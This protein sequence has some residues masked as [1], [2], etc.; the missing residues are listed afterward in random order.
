V[1][2]DA[3]I[4]TAY[5]SRLADYTTEAEIRASHILFR[6]EGQDEETVR[7]QAEQVLQEA[8]S[9]A[10]FAELARKYS[11]DETNREQGGDLDYF[12]R[13]RMVAEFDEAA[14]A[15]DNGQISDLVR[16]SFGFHII[17]LTDKRDATV[18]TLAEVRPELLEEL[19][20]A[21]A[22]EEIATR[23][24]QLA[25]RVRAPDDL[26]S[27][28]ASL[29]L[30]VQESS[31]FGRDD[32]VPGLGLAPAIAERAFTMADDEVGGPVRASRGEVFFV[33]D[34]RQAAYT[35]PFDDVRE[36]VRAAVINEKATALARQEAEGLATRLRDALD[37]TGAAK[38]AGFESQVTDLV[39]RDSVLPTLGVSPA[40]DRAAFSI[41][42]GGVSD[43][44]TAGGA[45]GIIKVLE[46]P[47][48]PASDFEAARQ[49]FR[50]EILNERRGRF[51]AAYMERARL[52]IPVEV[53]PQAMQR[54][55]S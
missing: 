54:A 7:A 5:N 13:G 9:G 51:F 53:N 29:G 26:Q 31:F 30:T 39:P 40:A 21:A 4:E 47:A 11:N 35:P 12:T 32:L 28:A 27:V 18:R 17:K 49:T 52:R 2:T 1:V 15:L 48:V 20:R 55:A 19:Q 43:P 14:F 45:L 36:Q 22:E 10:D 25:S 34:G 46:R 37:F 38:A 42:V 41:A 3:Q 16:S 24:E 50:D 33:L 8:R 44:I 6:T 23:A